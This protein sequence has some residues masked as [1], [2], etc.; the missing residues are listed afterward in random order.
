MGNLV[1]WLFKKKR[2]WAVGNHI[3]QIKKKVFLKVKGR[4]TEA[5]FMTSMFNDCL[6]HTSETRRLE[7]SSIQYPQSD[8]R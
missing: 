4:Q 6:L 2:N 5:V 7:V 1:G 3:V 8:N